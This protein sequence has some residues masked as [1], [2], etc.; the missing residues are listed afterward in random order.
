MYCYPFSVSLLQNFSN[1]QTDI[2]ISKILKTRCG[3]FSSQ[4]CVSSGTHCKW[5][6]GRKAPSGWWRT[7][8]T[9]SSGDWSTSICMRCNPM[10]GTSKCK[11][12]GYV[13]DLQISVASQ[14]ILLCWSLLQSQSSEEVHP[15]KDQW[16]E[17]HGI[18]TVF[19]KKQPSHWGSPVVG[20]YNI[21][22]IIEI[23]ASLTNWVE[24]NNQFIN[25]EIQIKNNSPLVLAW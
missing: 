6:A 10:H 12:A 25:R 20:I 8:F 15:H 5:L 4:V 23:S 16:G 2:F 9:N 18:L 24:I 3:F 19:E 13:S 22:V 21:L 1:I 14:I 11:H 7:G 17:Q